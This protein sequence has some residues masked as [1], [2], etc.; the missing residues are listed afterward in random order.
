MSKPKWIIGVDEAGR[1]PLAGPVA[2]GVVL[3]PLDFNWQTFGPV[4]DSK[5]LSERHR[6]EIYEAVMG[7]ADS[8]A[9]YQAVCMAPATMIDEAGIVPAIRY[10]MAAGLTDVL[11]QA[12]L[13][14]ELVTVLLDGSLQAPAEFINQYTI[15]KG[16]QTEPA[17]S[18]ASILAKVTRDRYM[19]ALGANERYR[20]YD[21]PRHKGYGTKQHRAAIAAAGPSPEHRKT[22]CGNIKYVVFS[23]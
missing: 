20:P 2:V 3:A 5:Q 1:G 19:V 6:D 8:L 23:Q 7:K 21:F 12:A 4:K 18:T 15:I 10:A 22:F 13:T 14:P 11:N 16:D 9:V 17:I